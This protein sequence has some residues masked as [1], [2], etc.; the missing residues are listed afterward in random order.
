MTSEIAESSSSASGDLSRER[1]DGD[2]FVVL[3]GSVFGERFESFV[4]KGLPF[5][6]ADGLDF[7]RVTALDEIVSK[8]LHS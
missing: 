5:K 3:R 6:S 2:G 4:R 8:T 7:C 1:L